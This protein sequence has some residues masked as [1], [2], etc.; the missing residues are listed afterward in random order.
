MKIVLNLEQSYFIKVW[1][2]DQIDHLSNYEM[3]EFVYEKCGHQNAF[4]VSFETVRVV[5]L[6]W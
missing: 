2:T 4:P 1:K 3:L 5:N 6:G